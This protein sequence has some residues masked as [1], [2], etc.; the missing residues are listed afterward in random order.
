M[1]ATCC[2][3]GHPSLSGFVL[4]SARLIVSAGP[5]VSSSIAQIMPF[6]P[7]APSGGHKQPY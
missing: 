5:R 6:D 1:R 4:L 3:I 2:W 7:P